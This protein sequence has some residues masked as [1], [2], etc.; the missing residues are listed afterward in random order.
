MFRAGTGAGTGSAETTRQQSRGRPW[1]L[2]PG[3][4]LS[5]QPAGPEAGS[6]EACQHA[7]AAAN[8]WPSNTT[9]R[10]KTATLLPVFTS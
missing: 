1:T 10:A 7:H 6:V 2:V 9:S 3:P 5:W 4:P 8:G